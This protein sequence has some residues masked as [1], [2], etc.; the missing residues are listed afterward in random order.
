M[1][2]FSSDGFTLSDLV[3]G[4]TSGE[5]VLSLMASS[6]TPNETIT[7]S[8]LTPWTHQIDEKLHVH[9]VF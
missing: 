8:D 7:Q 2:L 3:L 6:L 1:I 5:N 4:S 9:K